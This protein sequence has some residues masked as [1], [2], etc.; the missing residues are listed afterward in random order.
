MPE[1]YCIADAQVL[2][3]I[4]ERLSQEIIENCDNLD[5]WALLGLQ[6]KGVFL[7]DRI[8]HTIEKN[9]QQSLK[10]GDI[11]YTFFR[12]DLRT[13]HKFT[14]NKTKIE[15]TLQDKSIILVDD[16]LYTGRSLRATLSA[17]H[18]FGRPRK[19]K[20]MVLVDR[21]FSR[22]FPI[23]ADY[24]GRT[25]HTIPEQRVTV[26][27]QELGHQKEGIWIKSTPIQYNQD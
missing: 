1:A 9:S 23:Q 16:V 12:D 4:I 2:S 20:L 21:R 18:S 8:R 15:F 26:C 27:L 19:V 3:L 25:V 13:N 24:V 17:L 11:D 10:K 14:V 7:A 5:E 22:D 6:P